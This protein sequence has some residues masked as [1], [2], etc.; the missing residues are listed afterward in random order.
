[1][2]KQSG[3]ALWEVTLGFSCMT[4]GRAGVGG[5]EESCQSLSCTG[6]PDS[7][8]ADI[9]LPGVGHLLTQKMRDH[10]T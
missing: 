1:M 10:R 8:R 3:V 4:E 2:D 9:Q 5:H 7:M 6:R